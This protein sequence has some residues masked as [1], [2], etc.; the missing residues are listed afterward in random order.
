MA[1]ENAQ[2]LGQETKEK[3][4]SHMD[5]MK[6][7][8]ANLR[9]DFNQLKRDVGSLINTLVGTGKE[10]AHLAK[11]KLSETATM[12]K[13]RAQSGIESGTEQIGEA[14]EHA[15]DYSSD[16]LKVMEEKIAANPLAALALAAGL[17]LVVGA[18]MRRK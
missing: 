5:E 12:A 4:A 3:V 16:A 2:E 18:M 8:T 17:G 1:V 11:E 13:D 14:W 15:K 6:A 10:G 7:T 9:E